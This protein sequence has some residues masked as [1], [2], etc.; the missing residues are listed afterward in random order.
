MRVVGV[1]V[2]EVVVR[3]FV[4]FLF[5]VVLARGGIFHYFYFIKVDGVEEGVATGVAESQEQG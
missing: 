4:E 2:V 3:E 5:L 1:G